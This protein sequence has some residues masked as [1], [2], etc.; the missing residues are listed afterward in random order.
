MT[1]LHRHP[2]FAP[3]AIGWAIA[4]AVLTLVAARSIAHLWFPDADDAMRL[5]QVRD[6]LAGQ[7]W[8]DVSQHRLWG[9]HFAMHW[10]RLVDLPLAAVM[11][12]F[13]PLVGPAA[14]NRIAM[15]LVPLLTL[16]VVMALGAELTRRLAGLERAKLAVL[17]APLSVPLLFQLRPL[18]IDHH[19]WQIALAMLAAVVLVGRPS[20]RS[21]VIM[22]G[23]LAVLLTISL[24]GLPVSA[25]MIAMAM[26]AW[27]FDPTRRP[28]AMALMGTL[29][30]GIV[31][32]HVATR[33]PAMFQPACDAVA[34]AW[35]VAIWVAATGFGAA[36]LVPAR[37]LVARLA[38]LTLAGG[39]ALAAL[40]GMAPDCVRGPFASLD[41]LVYRFWYQNVSEGL[42]IWQQ[43]LAWA[44]MTAGFPVVGL[45]G[46]ILAR[47]G[48]AGPERVRWTMMLGLASASF[49]L[50][51]LVIRTGATA[52]AL[53]LPGGAWLLHAMLVRARAVRSLLP[54]IAATAGALVAAAPGL[55]AGGLFD[56][57]AS[58][59]TFPVAPL[60]RPPCTH[61]QEMADLAQLP[62]SLLFAPID[63]T[64][65]LIGWTSHRAIAGGYHRNVAAMH[66][67]IATFI[68]DPEE[69]H[70]SVLA[71]GARYVVGCPGENETE[72]YKSAA[73]N[74][75]WAQLERG[76]RF[77][78]LEPVPIA[79]SP[80]LAWRVVYPSKH[81]LSQGG[82]R[83]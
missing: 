77:D 75:F 81:G 44:L 13:D 58:P 60:T 51:L 14:S 20:A 18:R 72:I 6:W 39:A 21:G 15:T 12:A 45:M 9:G 42:P 59:V 32:L 64:P 63:A 37:S 25:V 31:L 78:W 46:T 53:A 19:G 54:R 70:R 1:A 83:P 8:W 48:A 33:G 24:E 61:S 22:G 34:P 62:P 17:L 3:V 47:R 5:L 69:A 67:V 35:I 11:L 71:S 66:R 29:A 36:M 7:S 16:L 65:A 49:A 50:S 28:Q 4:A 41:P 23:A 52:N 82:S 76:E 43:T 2:L 73:P 74:G 38:L 68:A 27:A 80:V 57:R 56:L 30:G 79:H 40:V 26:L 55:A 10:S